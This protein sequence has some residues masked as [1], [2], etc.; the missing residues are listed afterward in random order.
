MGWPPDVAERALLDCG[1]HCCLCHKFCG[2][3]IEL[4]HIVQR[5]DGGE[6]SYENCIPLCLECHAEVK[7]YDPNHPIGRKY[8][9]SELRE[10]RDR[11]Y[12]KVKDSSGIT[13]N[14]DYLELDRQ[15]FLEIREILPDT[16]G[17]IEF[18]RN[19]DY[20]GVFDTSAHVDF[21]GFQRR[22]ESPDFEFMDMDL[23]GLRVRLAEQIDELLHLVGHNVFTL[24]GRTDVVMLRPPP[25][26]DMDLVLGLRDIA[27]DEQ[28]LESRIQK[29]R[30]MHWEVAREA[31]TLADRIWDT[32]KE[33]IRLGRRKLAV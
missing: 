31:N 25:E 30:Q 27:K 14:P 26:K 4:H 9:E 13:S 21:N 12:K 28:D 11:W 24:P 5:K 29:A 10:H 32:Y 20:A 1:R 6:D 3:K 19:G 22:C 17:S 16:S 7:A 18:V 15:L 33:L 2:F 8:T 23:E